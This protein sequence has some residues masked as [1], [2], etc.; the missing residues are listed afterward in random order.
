MVTHM[1]FGAIYFHKDYAMRIYTDLTDGMQS[2]LRYRSGGHGELW[3]S[4]TYPLAN[5]DNLRQKMVETY[6]TNLSPEQR[7][8]RRKRDLPVGWGCAIPVLGNPYQV[9]CILLTEG[10]ARTIQEGPFSRE[11]WQ[12][13]LLEVGDFVLAHEPRSTRGYVW[14]WRLQDRALGLLEKQLTQLVREGVAA[15]VA[16]TSRY[17][18]SL[19]PMFSGVRR[20]LGRLFRSLAKLWLAMHKTPWPGADAT[21]LPF[22]KG[23]RVPKEP[24][25]LSPASSTDQS[26]AS[27]A[28]V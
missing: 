2:I 19:Y 23:F 17:W 18:V 7:K 10:C 16:S 8:L 24:P 21:A 20:Q 5:V 12:T 14:T 6:G 28:K 1:L 9:Q 25:R 13:K 26:T 4:F 22:I 27:S 15:R 3:V 11:K